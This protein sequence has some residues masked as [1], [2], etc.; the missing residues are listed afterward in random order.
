[1]NINKWTILASIALVAALAAILFHYD[2]GSPDWLP[3][4]L[5][6]GLIAI[7]TA[8]SPQ[9]LRTTWAQFS[10]KG[11]QNLFSNLYWDFGFMVAYGAL[12]VLLALVARRRGGGIA[13]IAAIIAAI[14]AVATV[15]C[16]I[17]ENVLTLASVDRL[18][19]GAQA[20]PQIVAATRAAS[21]A[22][23]ALTGVVVLSLWG[24][25]VPSR[26][27]SATYRLIAWGVQFF[28][29]LS[30]ALAL[31]GYWDNTKI[32]SVISMLFPAFVGLAIIAF[33]YWSVHLGREERDRS[34]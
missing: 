28:L 2:V 27:G 22:K 9:E 20:N 3:R 1:M 5:D 16:D 31:L 29:I 30:G 14:A 19:R 23:W 13:R 26:A 8:T 15:A 25:V 11:K 21:L 32:E 33:R 24:A 6:R 4:C 17:T 12:F 18:N 7:E 10:E 34:A